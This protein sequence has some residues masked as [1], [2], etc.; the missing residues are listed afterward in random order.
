MLS[1]RYDRQTILPEI[2]EAGQKKLLDSSAL[3]VGCGGLASTLLYC[4]CGM[5]V[6][7]IGFCDGDVVSPS[8]LNRQFLHNVADLGRR[9]TQSAFEKLSA[10]APELT[11]EPFG[12]RLT[13]KNAAEIVSR[14]DIVLLAVDSVASRLT[15]NRACVAAGV[16]LIDGGIHGLRGSLFTVRPRKTACLAC[17][18]GESQPSQIS[19]P[20][21]APVVSAISAMQAQTTANL[22]L[23][24][25]NPTDG[26]LLLFDGALLTTEFV[27]IRRSACCPVC[28][29]YE[30]TQL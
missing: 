2:G 21:F 4:L 8:N 28:G 1:E 20:S 16:P 5:G 18:Y 14:Y 24:L 22:L 10:F 17:F 9:K 23:G 11:L 30:T 29:K 26:Q 6:G 12:E 13:D 25:P 15:A 7:R 3:V 27:S 19:I